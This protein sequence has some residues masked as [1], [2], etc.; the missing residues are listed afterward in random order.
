MQ[1]AARAQ[2]LR[3]DLGDLIPRI[4]HFL[5]HSADGQTHMHALNQAWGTINDNTIKGDEA[6]HNIHTI[7]GEAL[8]A[9]HQAMQTRDATDH[10]R[11]MLHRRQAGE[12]DALDALLASLRKTQWG[13]QLQ[14]HVT[15]WSFKGFPRHFTNMEKRLSCST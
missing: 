8:D 14:E 10:S 4:N 2:T 5:A 9:I 13:Q 15:T 11:D 12:I 3:D 1:T 7:I 6:L